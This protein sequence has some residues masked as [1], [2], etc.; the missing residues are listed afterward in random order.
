MDEIRKIVLLGTGIIA[1][2]IVTG[3]IILTFCLATLKVPN[4]PALSTSTATTEQE[5]KTKEIANYKELVLSMQA[6]RTS[7]FDYVVLKALLPLFGYLIASVLT[8]IFAKTALLAYN[9]YLT[10]KYKKE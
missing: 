8:Y 5:A 7:I 9:T 1:I 10:Q 6:Q 3:S 4:P 2:L